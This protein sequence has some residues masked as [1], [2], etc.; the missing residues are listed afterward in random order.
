M[1]SGA[2]PCRP[3]VNLHLPPQSAARRGPWRKLVPET[4]RRTGR[5]RKT[6]LP[7]RRGV[8][9]SMTAA[10]I[11]LGITPLLTTRPSLPMR[12]TQRR[13]LPVGEGRVSV[14]LRPRPRGH[15]HRRSLHPRV[16]PG[17]IP[18]KLSSRTRVR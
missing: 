11:T 10:M 14:R 8:H 12:E 1:T 7:F 6:W 15:Q 16:Q 2:I 5:V 13:T 17:T 4:R 9:P 18:L 3:P